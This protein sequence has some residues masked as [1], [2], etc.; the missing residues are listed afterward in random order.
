MLMCLCCFSTKTRAT[1]MT[2]FLGLS[3]RTCSVLF[4]CYLFGRRRVWCEV[5]CS[6]SAN[7]NSRSLDISVNTF[8]KNIKRQIYWNFSTERWDMYHN[9]IY[10]DF[11]YGE[12]LFILRVLNAVLRPIRLRKGNTRT[13]SL[14]PQPKP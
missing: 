6:R 8:L 1:V 2:G 13:L 10:G 14:T 11:N 9:S 3:C 12:C 7:K 4:S 5:M